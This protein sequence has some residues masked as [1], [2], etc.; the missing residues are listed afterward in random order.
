MI[1]HGADGLS[2]LANEVRQATAGLRPHRKEF[3]SIVVCG[4]SGIFRSAK[5]R[6]ITQERHVA[7][8]APVSLR[9]NRPLVVVRKPADTHRTGFTF[10]GYRL[11]ENWHHAGKR[12]VW[13]D[14]FVAGGTTRKIVEDFL[15]ERSTALQEYRPRKV[16]EYMYRNHTYEVNGWCAR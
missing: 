1:Y 14:D 9:L 6:R 5:S 12:Y 3:D 13:L 2:D 7:V 16:A 15:D 8:G 11:V 10:D 4:L